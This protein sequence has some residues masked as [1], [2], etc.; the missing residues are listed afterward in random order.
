MHNSQGLSGGSGTG[1]STGAKIG[2]GVGI[3]GGFLL[4]ALIALIVYFM[5]PR[6]NRSVTFLKIGF[7][8]TGKQ[9]QL[10]KTEEPNRKPSWKPREPAVD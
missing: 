5:R 2:L 1:L 3:P 6:S 4:L 9:K 7:P 8:A 10:T